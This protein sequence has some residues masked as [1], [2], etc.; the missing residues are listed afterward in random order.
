MD[1][2]VIIL[3]CTEL[4]GVTATI[5][6]DDTAMKTRSFKSMIKSMIIST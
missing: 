5:V 1:L 3:S 6:V 4:Y 2:C